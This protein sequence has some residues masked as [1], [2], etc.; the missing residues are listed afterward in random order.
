MMQSIKSQTRLEESDAKGMDETIRLL[1]QRELN[2]KR[3]LER[4][5][6]DLEKIDEELRKYN[7]SPS[8]SPTHTNLS[9]T[10]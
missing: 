8:G 9:S 3:R 10:F 6:Q 7:T 5:N 1:L 2:A 4:M